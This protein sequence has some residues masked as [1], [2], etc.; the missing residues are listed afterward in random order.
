MQTTETHTVTLT[1]W[2]SKSKLFLKT[3]DDDDFKYVCRLSFLFQIPVLLLFL[4]F[5][6]YGLLAG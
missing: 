1:E 3:R 2:I 5:I 4:K 6:C